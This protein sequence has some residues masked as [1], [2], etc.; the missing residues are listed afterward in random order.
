[1]NLRTHP[2]TA[3]NTQ[4]VKPQD[5]SAI[6]I[7]G[8]IFLI[9]II[10][11]LGI[12]ISISRSLKED[13][14][15]INIA[16]RQRMLSQRMT[17]AQLS[18]GEKLRTDEPEKLQKALKELK[19]TSSLFDDSLNAFLDGG[20]ISGAD[21]LPVT[22]RKVED[23]KLAR[24][25]AES[26]EIWDEITNALAPLVDG[27]PDTLSE[28]KIV[29]AN[30]KLSEHNLTLLRLM[31]DL[32]VGLEKI[33]TQKSA[34]LGW[35]LLG[36]ALFVIINFVYIVVLSINKLKKGD[37][38]L[39]QYSQSLASNNYSLLETNQQLETT[40]SQLQE[41]YQSLQLYSQEADTRA[42]E[43]Q[44]LSSN[45]SRMKEESDAIFQSI[46][47]GLFLVDQKFCIG[48]RISSAMH[49]IFETKELSGRNFLDLMRPLVSEKDIK[50]LESYLKLQF[51]GKTLT[52][53]L[54]KFN[55]LKEIELTMNWDGQNFMN[56]N[57]SFEF[58]R[59]MEGK[60]VIDILVTVTD[61]TEKVA[62]ENKLKK[63]S[64]DE[65][66]KT[67]AILELIQ[68]DPQELDL[69]L[70]QA[71]KTLDEINEALKR[72]G[73]QDT[74]QLQP[75]KKSDLVEFIFRKIHNLKGNASMLGLT[76]LSETSHLI[77]NDLEKLRTR[78]QISGDDFLSSLVHMVDLRENI[79]HYLEVKQT[80]LKNF[81]SHNKTPKASQSRSQ[82]LAADLNQLA[83][84]IADESNK[85][86]FLRSSFQFDDFS[87]EPYQQIKDVLIQLTRNSVVHGIEAKETRL[88]AG[89]L[90]DGIIQIKSRFDESRTNPLGEP[91]YHFVY[92]DDGAGLNL[93]QIKQQALRQDLLSSEEAKSLSPSALARFIFSPGFSTSKGVTDHA[94]RGA[95]MDLVKDIIIDQ[96]G[97]KM[98][99]SYKVNH[100]FQLSW[101]IPASRISQ[102]I[103]ASEVSV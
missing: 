103:A 14:T 6:Q 43:L 86:V 11:A 63:A 1:M 64:E 85:S 62:M 29:Y 52:K 45:L 55:P 36:A 66:K 5:Y 79:T 12:N 81:V 9:I 82:Q 99:L 76:G 28:T 83:Q 48:N 59:V 102:K 90:E 94:G 23:P 10:I 101:I 22:I 47:H 75:E 56:K 100:H 88:A 27:R 93:E 37:L 4:V 67:E 58:E 16:G 91:A 34:T 26:K 46:D 87:P 49:R 19:V 25:L 13:A 96:L 71:E 54:N 51:N 31:N 3:E 33:S 21:G 53:Q 44:D 42:N 39:Q 70:T 80:L 92:R 73:I 68:A 97:G 98:S 8:C 32:T 61:I 20:K 50:T 38:L 65:S 2:N 18:I 15:E 17:K 84:R 69:F 7:A 60:K 57:V 30:D 72:Q 78:A 74:E 24:T 40:Q 35:V 95:G 41:A 77:E 89:K